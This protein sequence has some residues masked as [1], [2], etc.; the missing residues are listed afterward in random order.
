M[1]HENRTRETAA[2]GCVKER[3]LFVFPLFFGK[4]VFMKSRNRGRKSWHGEG[5][6]VDGG[7]G[8]RRGIKRFAGSGW[9]FVRSH[10]P[11]TSPPLHRPFFFTLNP[12]SEAM[13]MMIIDDG[14][15]MM[16]IMASASSILHV[17]VPPVSLQIINCWV[18]LQSV[19]G[20]VARNHRCISLFGCLPSA[21]HGCS[22]DCRDKVRRCIY[23]GSCALSTKSS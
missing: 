21:Q 1:S 23:I 8:N 16:M 15:M 3:V 12:F 11:R 19:G 22:R 9:N 20:D 7:D 5:F 10:G 17:G 13:L 14:T 18:G 6:Q 4:K 2:T